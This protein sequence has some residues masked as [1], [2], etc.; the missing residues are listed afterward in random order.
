MRRAPSSQP[1]RS[2]FGPIRASSTSQDEMASS[3]TSAKSSP[4]PIESTSM[5]TRDSP[6]RALRLS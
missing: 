5:N 2:Q 4:R 3:I 6:K 1:A